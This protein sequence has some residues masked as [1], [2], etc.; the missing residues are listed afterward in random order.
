MKETCLVSKQP[1]THHYQVHGLNDR[2]FT[3]FWCVNVTPNNP[4]RYGAAILHTYGLVT[5]DIT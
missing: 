3:I 1:G 5:T 4:I 2:I